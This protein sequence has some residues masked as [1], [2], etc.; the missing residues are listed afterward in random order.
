M[1]KKIVNPTF[2]EKCWQIVGSN[3]FWNDVSWKNVGSTFLKSFGSTFLKKVGLKNV[4]PTFTEKG[5][6]NISSE[7]YCEE[8]QKNVDF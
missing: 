2:S 7:K 8:E 1:L 4:G 6:K 5:W 3:I